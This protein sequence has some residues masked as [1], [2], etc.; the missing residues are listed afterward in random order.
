[1][2]VSPGT[3]LGSYTIEAPVGAGGMGEVYRAR[4]S[5]LQRTVAIKVLPDMA[6]EEAIRRLEREAFSA[7]GLNHPNILTVYEFGVEEGVHYLA[8]EFV[9]GQTLRELIN[10]GPLPIAR[11]LD[12]A[13]QIGVALEAAHAAGLVHRDIKPENVMVRPDGYVKVLDFG[14]ATDTAS[15]PSSSDHETAK[16]LT[17]PG[18]ILGTVAYMSPEQIRG[19]PID[20]R[21]DIWSLGVLIHEMVCG[22]APFAAPTASDLIAAVLERNPPPL[23]SSGIDAPPEL[24]RIIDKA[25][26]KDRGE[27]YQTMTDAVID[28]R[29][30]KQELDLRKELQ[31]GSGAVSALR[32]TAPEMPRVPSK[33][34]PRLVAIVAIAAFAAS[35]AWGALALWRGSRPASPGNT[36]AS[37]PRRIDYWLTVQRV[38]DG[39]PYG[40]PFQAS[41]QEIF[42][43]GWKFH[44]NAESPERGFFY[45]IS[46]GPGADG[47]RVLRLLFPTP[48]RQNGSAEVLPGE[49]LQI[50]PYIVQG[51]SGPEVFWIVWSTRQVADLEAAKRWVNPDDLG[52]VKDAVETAAIDRLLSAPNADGP[53][54]SKATGRTVVK[55]S[56]DPLVFKAELKHQH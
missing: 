21:A 4:D 43:D 47:R 48:S 14:I 16:R 38:R 33:G 55:G 28:L 22:H 51:T 31:R 42:E 41:G 24:I 6:D 54:E 20:A 39:K 5:R 37:S 52:V 23:A 7:S 34:R 30:L 49:R 26:A 17:L 46:L 35:L 50:G 32:G 1:M 40:E 15:M 19:L 3:R 44:L 11:A 56:A 2:R 36:V 27:R 13:I 12:I 29:R 10:G 9:E 53:L 45:L 18:T 8:T 25:L